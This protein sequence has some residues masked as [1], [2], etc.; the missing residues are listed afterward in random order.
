MERGQSFAPYTVD[1]Q[2][3]LS[4]MHQSLLRLLLVGVK[5]VEGWLWS[6]V[7]GEGEGLDERE[8]HTNPSPLRFAFPLS[9]GT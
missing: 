6:G 5:K 2:T 4:Q 7:R 3:T 9:L 1:I 8:G